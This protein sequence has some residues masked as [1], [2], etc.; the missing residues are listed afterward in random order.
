MMYLFRKEKDPIDKMPKTEVKAIYPTIMLLGV[1]ITLISASFIPNKPSITNGLICCTYA[2]ITLII[3]YIKN[4]DS[5]RINHALASLDFETLFLL[6]GLFCVIAGIKQVGVID[7][8]ANLIASVGGNNLFLLYTIVVWGS[9]IFSA[10]IDNIPYVA[11]ML[12]IL[13]SV[14]NV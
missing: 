7:D 10:F 6:A 2:L 13:M 11:T 3:D 1:V 12:P 5:K 9:V 8:V 14:S 4:K